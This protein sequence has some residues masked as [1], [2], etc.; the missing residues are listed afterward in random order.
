MDEL[1]LKNLEVLNDIKN[2]F[3]DIVEENK[4]LKIELEK[5]K[6]NH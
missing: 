6:I 4:L 2:K 1:I 3:N 5:K